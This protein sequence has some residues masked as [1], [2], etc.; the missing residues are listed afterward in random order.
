MF[1][2]S[3]GEHPFFISTMRTFLESVFN[4]AEEKGGMLS[5]IGVGKPTPLSRQFKVIAR[6][7]AIVAGPLTPSPRTSPSKSSTTFAQDTRTAFEAMRTRKDYSQFSGAFS[8]VDTYLTSQGSLSWS[9]VREMFMKL[10][11]LNFENVQFLNILWQDWVFPGAIK[12]R[13][14]SVF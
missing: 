2:S 7:L 3:P 11:K 6:S 12:K 9:D 4:F 14:L 5:A 13:R 1:F 10:V 8:L